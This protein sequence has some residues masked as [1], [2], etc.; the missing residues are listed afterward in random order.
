[1]ISQNIKILEEKIIG[2]CSKSGRKRSDITLIGISKTQPV[3]RIKEAFECG[4]NNFGEN[5]A[6]EFAKKIGQ[7]DDQIIWHFV[8]HLQSNKVKYV[9]PYAEYIHS[10]DSVKLADEINTRAGK[11]NK[12]QKILLEV[13]TS[14][15]DSKFGLSS[16][17]ELYYLTEYCIKCSNLKPVGLMTMA[18]FVSNEKIIKNCFSKL[19]S[20]LVDLNGKG[21]AMN[22]LSMGM[23]GD[24]QFAIE[25]GATMLR[26]G[27][28]IFGERD[29][30]IN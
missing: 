21:F 11:I 27:T 20:I 6:Q 10:V 19:R 23:T 3:E 4:I 9:V 13:N 30:S 14:G 8:G 16:L 28:A 7:L 29:Y 18:P 12:V 15:E 26:I 17:D 22:E 5:K 2:V 25:E 1:M 24:Y